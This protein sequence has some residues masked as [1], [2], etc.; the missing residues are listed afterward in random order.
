VHSPASYSVPERYHLLVDACPSSRSL[1]G[2]SRMTRRAATASVVSPRRMSSPARSTWQGSAAAS[3]ACLALP[4]HDG[5]RP[6]AESRVQVDGHESLPPERAA[7]A[8]A[9]ARL[10]FVAAAFACAAFSRALASSRGQTRSLMLLMRRPRPPCQRSF[11]FHR[12]LPLIS[13]D[14]CSP[15]TARCQ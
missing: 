15:A 11:A 8:M 1:S 9:L 14:P 13:P 2:A 6:S 12:P 4:L 10:R 7:C 3:G 5:G